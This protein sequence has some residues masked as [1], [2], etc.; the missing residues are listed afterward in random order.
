MMFGKIFGKTKTDEKLVTP[1]I[2]GL[3]IGCSF[4]VDPLILKLLEN[5]LVTQNISTTHIIQAAGK[6]ELDDALLYRFYSDDEGFL[7]VV[8][9]GGTADENVIDV[10]LYHY[11]DTLDV[12]SERDWDRL[13]Y[14]DIGRP[15]YQL[16]EH[17]YQRVWTA[18][19]DYHKPVH[20]SETTY[21]NQGMTSVTDQ[22]TML[23][24]RPIADDRTESL[25]LSAEE[26][27]E[28][29]GSLSRCFVISTGITLTPTQ[30][31]I[32]G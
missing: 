18:T 24:E 4:E 3:R 14:Q 11:F 5:D 29:A 13:L 23:F 7:Q 30:I 20:M 9:Q 17:I 27:E 22:F 12:S 32:H 10:K 21:D 31:S 8:A 25:F 15:T 6:V 1:S 16:Q 28:P 19:S 2:L 26:K